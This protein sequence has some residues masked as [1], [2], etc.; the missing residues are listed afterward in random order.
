LFFA[1]VEEVKGKG[2]YAVDTK[3]NEYKVGSANFVNAAN[4]DYTIYVSKNNGL[5]GWI[6]VEDGLQ[7]KVNNVVSWNKKQAIT[8]YI[9]SGDVQHKVDA[10]AKQT[11]IDI[12]YA[13]QTPAKKL[14]TIQSLKQKG[15]TA[16]VGDGINDAP[17]LAAADIG[18]A[19]GNASQLAVLS[20]DVVL[21]NKNIGKLPL[22]MQLGAATSNTIKQN[23][24][25][26]F[27][28]NIVAIP[29]AAFGLLTPTVA[30]LVMAFSDV[31]LVINSLK[32]YKTK[33][34]NE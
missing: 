21:L 2:M 9:I 32:L 11:G 28:Y 16:M 33:L 1:K 4:N 18:I 7:P 14:E 20:A 31:F 15:L 27:A 13:E 24:F 23:L 30:A 5:V 8:N 3:G 26:A 19:V 10:I 29:I 17:A 6:N 34:I 25:W 22:A 12:V